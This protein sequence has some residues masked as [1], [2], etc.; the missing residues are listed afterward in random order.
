MI[1]LECEVNLISYKKLQDRQD[2]LKEH[3]LLRFDFHSLEAESKYL[4]KTVEGFKKEVEELEKKVA[5][6]EKEC[7]EEKR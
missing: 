7:E 5:D 6:L 1:F 4:E 2:L 3:D